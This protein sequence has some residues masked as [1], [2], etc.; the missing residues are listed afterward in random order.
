MVKGV[1][2][3]II[4]IKETGNEYFEKIILYVSPKYSGASPVKIQKAVNSELEKINGNKGTSGKSLRQ[5][6][7]YRKRRRVIMGVCF[8]M[9][10]LVCAMITAISLI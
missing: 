9:A 10:I 1:N 8:I 2:K 7:S 3:T 6:I 4:E 5:V